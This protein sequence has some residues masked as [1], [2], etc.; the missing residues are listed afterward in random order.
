MIAS[1]A[2]RSGAGE[3]WQNDS[4]QNDEA[5]ES[6]QDDGGKTMGPVSR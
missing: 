2:V 3:W 1:G 6:G 4:G 5:G